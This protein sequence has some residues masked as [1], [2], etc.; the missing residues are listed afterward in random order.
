M[1]MKIHKVTSFEVDYLKMKGLG[2]IIPKLRSEIYQT[3]IK[4]SIFRK[5]INKNYNMRRN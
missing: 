3:D 4:K 5:I 1:L 2:R